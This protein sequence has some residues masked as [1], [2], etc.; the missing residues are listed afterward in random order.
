MIPADLAANCGV[1]GRRAG[2]AHTAQTPSQLTGS[3][4]DA[5]QLLS[6]AE[7]VVSQHD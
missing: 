3:A 2:V 6:H 1:S 5:A 7:D 4:G